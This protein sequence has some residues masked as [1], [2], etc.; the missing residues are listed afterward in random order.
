MTK[1]DDVQGGLDTSSELRREPSATSEPMNAPSPGGYAAS[2]GSASVD[3]DELDEILL[4]RRAWR[5]W[6]IAL[7][8]VVVAA[9][10]V[11]FLATS[12]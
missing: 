5:R 7:V 10:A 1:P 12:L 3:A 2:V 6:V 9:A 4:R 8:L 11:Y